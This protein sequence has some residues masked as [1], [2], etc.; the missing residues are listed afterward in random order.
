[1]EGV[2]HTSSSYK[3]VVGLLKQR[4]GKTECIIHGHVHALLSLQVPVERGK[5][6]ITQLWRL[7]D[8]VVEHTRSLEAK[9]I[10]GK[11]C[12]VLIT[13]MIVSRLPTEL[14]MLWSRA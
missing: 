1:M 14:R 2:P 12:E 10:T 9:G 4:F 11:Q 8:E 6:Y 7:R 5:T 3:T 13:L